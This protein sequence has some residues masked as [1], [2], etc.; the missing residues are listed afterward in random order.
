MHAQPVL[1]V[2]LAISCLSPAYAQEPA[3]SPDECATALVKVDDQGVLN[4]NALCGL[5]D[6]DAKAI[7]SVLTEIRHEL[8]PSDDQLRELLAADNLILGTVL[9]RLKAGDTDLDAVLNVL[10]LL[11]NKAHAAAG[12]NLTTE[13]DHWQGYYAS[14]MASLNTAGDSGP[15]DTGT[16]QALHSLDF[17][18]AAGLLDGL[19]AAQGGQATAEAG[20]LRAL[21]FLLQFQP[22]NALPLLEKAHQ[23]QPDSP[24]YG[25]AYNKALL[26]HQAQ[27][28][29]ESAYDALLGQYR[30][31]AKANPATY[32]PAVASALNNLGSV[33]SESKRTQ[34]A[35]KAY[36][37]AL[38]IRRGLTSDKP[39]A[40]R[41]AMALIL[42]N[43]A[44]LYAG[45]NRPQDAEKAWS[46]AGELQRE[47]A[48]SNPLIYQPSLAVTLHNLG[49]VY[50]DA[51][52]PDKAE[53]AYREALDIRTMLAKDQPA[54]YQPEMAVTLNNLGLMY[55]ESQRYEDAAKAYRE[56][57]AIQRELY[58]ANP[59]T[60]AEKLKTMLA[61]A[62]IL[63][64]KMGR[65]GERATLEAERAS[66]K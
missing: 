30:K 12:L 55:R 6:R 14:L 58:R 32:L 48:R 23:L 51:K 57:L 59:E 52:Q 63:M 17:D 16:L 38:D 61:G 49:N 62:A 60:Q 35:E 4:V 28:S 44:T 47:L 25:L 9:D 22:Q 33:Y 64:D 27:G 5:A 24:E 2:I 50:T 21:V 15:I 65:T 31:L 53:K 10:Q 7:E 40:N 34:E 36:R 1:A 56:A 42:S 66:V 29:A 13:A 3:A 41:A 37:E 26:E 19:L 43:L 18:L 45:T 54:T 20:Y 39:V 46:E 11:A 8:K